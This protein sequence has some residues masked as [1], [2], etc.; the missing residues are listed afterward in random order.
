[1]MSTIQQ[2][3]DMRWTL[4]VISEITVVLDRSVAIHR[5]IAQICDF[6]CTETAC[7]MENACT[8]DV[9]SWY[10]PI[11]FLSGYISDRY[12]EQFDLFSIHISVKTSAAILT[13]SLL[14]F[15]ITLYDHYVSDCLQ[16]LQS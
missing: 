3:L 5:Y 13:D 12:V 16:A 9:T 11:R 15:S 4:V 1:M 6:I 2:Q 10:F 8:S 7:R 14:L